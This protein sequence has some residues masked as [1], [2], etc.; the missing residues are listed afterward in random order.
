MNDRLSPGDGD[1]QRANPCR[2]KSEAQASAREK[3]WHQLVACHWKTG[4]SISTVNPTDMMV[5]I[6]CIINTSLWRRRT[7]GIDL[8][9]SEVLVKVFEMLVYFFFSFSC[10]LKRS[11]GFLSDRTESLSESLRVSCLKSHPYCWACF[12]GSKLVLR[13]AAALWNFGVAMEVSC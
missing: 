11:L 1:R 8:C 7:A 12:W 5:F 4:W 6:C 2:T 3:K 9:W 13:T 10:I